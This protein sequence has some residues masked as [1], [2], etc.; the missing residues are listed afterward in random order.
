MF[1]RLNKISADSF[2]T[3]II[4]VIAVMFCS[5]SPNRH[6]SK[7]GYLLSKNKI[8]IDN[9]SISKGDIVNYIQQDPNH[10]FLG[11]KSGMYIYSMSRPVD[12]T[13]CNFFEKYIF[14]AI[15]DK[16]VEI[17]SDL[18]DLS[19]KNIKTYLNTHGCF[20]SEVTS[21]TSPV[22]RWYAPWSYYK[23]RRTVNY[24]VHIPQ[25]AVIDTFI[26][27]TEDPHL[28]NTVKSLLN[29]REDNIKKGD[30]YNEDVMVA[31][32]SGVS[33]GML[34]KGYYAFAPKY[35]S[36]NVDTTQGIDKTKVIMVVKNPVAEDTDSNV[37]A[38]H[39]PYR[40]SKIYLHPNYISPTSPDYIPDKDTVLTYHKQQRGFAL[41][42]L[43]IMRNTSK[44]IIKEKTIMRSILMQNNNMF[45]PEISENTYSSL[46]QLRN[47]KYIDITYEDITKGI[48]DTNDLA[49][50]IKLT[51]NKPV[52][53]SS[54]FEL[55]YSAS[56]EIINNNSTS[57]NFGMAGNLSYTDKNLLHGAEIFTAN[58]KLAA[59]INSNIFR[60]D[61]ESSGW[62]IF[63]AF[64]A[65]VDFGIEL[66]RFLAPFS[67]NFYSM[68]FH[69]H[70]IYRNAPIIHALFL[71][72]TTVIRG[73][74][75]RKSIS[76]SFRWKSISSIWI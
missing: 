57:S 54:S 65:G 68:R 9:K 52:A 35:I 38:V 58:L 29:A 39:K 24:N 72:S 73:I 21:F 53:L 43:Y 28:Y 44:P 23:R 14:R 50:Y 69:P 8:T 49:C 75:R 34:T 13:A 36:F 40:I 59:E 4:L 31:I 41:T 76:A 64:E 3:I 37:S 66:P 25:R 55:N 61:N 1:D 74:R 6:L 16:P 33:S 70:T 48:K 17:N 32:R 26:L 15:G 47:F 27:Q 12:D 11:V 45:S 67:T 20:N 30:W 63:N 71:I 19:C 5:C 62:D 7:D 56:N 2:V 10:K 18:T 51:R 22:R 60:S 42:P 46:F